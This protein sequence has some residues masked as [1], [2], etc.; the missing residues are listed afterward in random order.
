MVGVGVDELGVYD[1]SD[2]TTDVSDSEALWA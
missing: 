1:S 2:A